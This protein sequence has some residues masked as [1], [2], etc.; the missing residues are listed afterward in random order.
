MHW[1]H[2]WLFSLYHVSGWVSFTPR[3]VHSKCAT[4]TFPIA[5]Y[6]KHGDGN[7][8][9]PKTSLTSLTHLYAL[10]SFQIL[11]CK[12][13]AKV[14]W[15]HRLLCFWI[16]V[17][18]EIKISKS[19]LWYKKKCSNNSSNGNWHH[20]SK[21]SETQNKMLWELTSP[22]KDQT[23]NTQLKQLQAAFVLFQSREMTL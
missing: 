16:Q 1:L 3:N 21:T 19:N 18:L 6:C 22:I 23:Q 4:P 17:L 12:C 9:I 15:K 7:T 20:C 13:N 11:Q 5:T 8:Y 10:M 2:F 14:K